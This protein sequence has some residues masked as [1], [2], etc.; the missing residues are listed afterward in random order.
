[1][2][3]IENTVTNVLKPMHRC[4]LLHKVYQLEC[5]SSDYQLAL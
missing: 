5:P 1:M 2:Q 4:G 3:R